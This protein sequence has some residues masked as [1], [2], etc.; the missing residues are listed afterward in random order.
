MVSGET[1]TCLERTV[2]VAGYCPNQSLD[3]FGFDVA[4]SEV[5]T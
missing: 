1:K 3:L 5:Q 4:A 2:Y